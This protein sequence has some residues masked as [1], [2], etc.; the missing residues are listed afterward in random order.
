MHLS[1]QEQEILDGRHGPTLQKVMKSL[2]L[3]EDQFQVDLSSLDPGLY[4]LNRRSGNG[5]GS[6]VK[7]I[8]E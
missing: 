5:S 3:K 8:V 1:Q 6:F 2:I 4:I 7:V